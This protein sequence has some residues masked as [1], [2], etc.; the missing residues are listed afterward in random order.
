MGATRKRSTQRE[1]DEIWTKRVSAL[2]EQAVQEVKRRRTNEPREIGRSDRQTDRQ[3]DWE[4]EHMDGRTA[5]CT[6]RQRQT[7]G[8]TDRQ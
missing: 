6:D 4:A 3:T 5:K 8:Q 2:C 7:D 1:K